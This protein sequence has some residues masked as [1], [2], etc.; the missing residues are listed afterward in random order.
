MIT[1]T[2]ELNFVIHGGNS[3]KEKRGIVKSIIDRIK[4]RYV[5]AI[6]EV[7]KNDLHR[8]GQLV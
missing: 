3:L 8:Y 7:T 4:N 6:A 5:T 2:V 1:G